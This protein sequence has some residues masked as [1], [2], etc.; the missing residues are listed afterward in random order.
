MPIYTICGKCGDKI[1]VGTKCERCTKETYRQYKH[2]RK[3]KREQQF[4]ANNQWKTLSEI[5][6]R[7]YLGMCLNCWD[8][9]IIE[10]CT[11]THHIVELKEDWNRR[12]DKDNLIPLCT[13][14]HQ[15]IHNE[16][17][18]NKAIEQARLRDILKKYKETYKL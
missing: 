17:K 8:K 18:N 2:Y 4:Y 10:M 5:I 11:T 7:R 14:C 12:L 1:K 13:R 3:D 6:K 16:Y 15:K 9:G